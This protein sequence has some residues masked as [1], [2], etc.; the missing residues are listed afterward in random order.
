MDTIAILAGL[1][2]TTAVV[3][4][5]LA[6]R[7]RL[8]AGRAETDL[9]LLSIRAEQFATD[10][11]A[12]GFAAA[13]LLRRTGSALPVIRLFLARGDRERRTALRL[14]RAGLTLRPGEYLMVRLFIAAAVGAVILIATAGSAIGAVGAVAAAVVGYILPDL[15]VGW[16]ISR[17]RSTLETQL[18]EMLDLVATSL[19]SG[20]YL[21][22]ALDTAS[23]HIGAPL[24]EDLQRVLTDVR[25]GRPLEDALAEWAVIVESRDVQL[26]VTAMLVQRTS[27]GDLTEV[28]ENLA[29]TMR[30]RMEV[31]RQV[32]ALTA[33]ARLAS[34]IIAG[35]PFVIALL[36]TAMRPGVW[37]AL[38]T[39]TAGLV[40]VGVS[41]TMSLIAFFVMSR[42]ARVA[43]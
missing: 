5:M 26:I 16:T 29:Q 34:R 3:F 36:L 14:R 24:S 21:M 28:L 33:Y 1:S 2:V 13:G 17:R 22:Q 38:W 18:V 35:Y 39:E 12:G 32:R 4:A 15:W 37:G 41:I 40:M 42:M 20:F 6:V 10:D 25:L 9:R 7:R 23:K 31:R 8:D 30:E 43:Y 27:G 19:K 11:E